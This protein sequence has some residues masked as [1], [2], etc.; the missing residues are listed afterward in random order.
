MAIISLR[1]DA[2]PVRENV[3]SHSPGATG[4]IEPSTRNFGPG[5]AKPDGTRAAGFVSRA[6]APRGGVLFDQVLKVT[7]GA[8]PR[9]GF[10]SA[11]DRR[12]REHHQDARPA[13]RDPH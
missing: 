7:R 9:S 2:P 13:S 3:D 11:Y 6:T 8:P 5:E 4:L 12:S 1:V 10:A